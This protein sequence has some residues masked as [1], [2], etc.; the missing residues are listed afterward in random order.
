[1][2]SRPSTATDGAFVS[3]MGGL[4]ERLE[5]DMPPYVA[6]AIRK[7]VREY[8]SQARSDLLHR[9]YLTQPMLSAAP[10]DRLSFDDLS[11]PAKEDPAPAYTPKEEKRR[12]EKLRRLE[13]KIAEIRSKPRADDRVVVRPSYSPA[14]LDALARLRID[15]VDDD[16]DR[17]ESGTIVVGE[18]VWKSPGRRD[19]LP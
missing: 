11:S 1:M 16:D 2:R 9:V 5:R 3:S 8:G 15:D 7:N 10:G 17:D 14:V 18:D 12:R 13:E 4:K 19:D 6:T